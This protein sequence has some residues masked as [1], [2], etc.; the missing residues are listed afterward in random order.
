MKKS[1]K[2]NAVALMQK[3]KSFFSVFIGK[4]VSLMLVAALIYTIVVNNVINE[5]IAY[6]SNVYGFAKDYIIEKINNGPVDGEGEEFYINR[7]TNSMLMR[8]EMGTASILFNAETGEIIADCKEK[9][10]YLQKRD[11]GEKMSLIYLANMEDIEGWSEYKQ[12]VIGYDEFFSHIYESCKLDNVYIKGS[13]MIPGEFTM[14]CDL[15]SGFSQE[16]EEKEVVTFKADEIPNGYEKIEVS[17]D[18]TPILIW[19]YSPDEP[20]TSNW[21]EESYNQLMEYYEHYVEHCIKGG[22]EVDISGTSITSGRRTFE[23]QDELLLANGEKAIL[24]TVLVYDYYDEYGFVMALAAV[25][26]FMLVLIVSLIWAKLSYTRLKARYDMEDYRKTLMNTMA[27][28]LKSPLMSISG[29]AENLRDNVN[30][31]KREHYSEAILGNVKYMNHIIESVL[32]LGKTENAALSLKKAKTS[33]KTIFLE[34]AKK[35]DLQM[36]EKKLTLNIEGDVELNI[37][38]SLFAQAVDNLL[39]N[40]VKFAS[41]DSPININIKDKVIAIANNCNESPDVDVDTLC[42]PFVVGNVNRS[43]KTGT[44]LGL[45]IVNNICQLHGMKLE[46]KCLENV[47]IAEISK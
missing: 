46:L 39:G 6:A 15:Y 23:G 33:I 26:T 17:E 16:L 45:A 25:I 1:K 21:S 34:C 42:K 43:D 37:D 18:G 31:D 14:K 47:F 4:W 20:N 32:A 11:N 3:R 12:R 38:A 7:V 9:M 30:T 2:R 19:G 41:E 27:H 24:M 44:G 22:Q 36:K 5:G 35:Y 40:A 28:D 29:Y 13:A 10:I 8:Q